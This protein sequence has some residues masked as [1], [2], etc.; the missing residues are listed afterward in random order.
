MILAL[1]GYYISRMLCLIARI[2]SKR[3]LYPLLASLVFIGHTWFAFWQM[4]ASLSSGAESVK[5]PFA[6]GGACIVFTCAFIA[7]TTSRSWAP[8]RD[9]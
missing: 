1:H 2:S 9:E 4:R 7:A 6:F 3:W 8:S 5:I